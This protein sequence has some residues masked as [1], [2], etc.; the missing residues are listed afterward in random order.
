MLAKPHNLYIINGKKIKR[1]KSKDLVKIN[2]HNTHAILLMNAVGKECNN[3]VM[4]VIQGC[5]I[6]IVHAYNH[7]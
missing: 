7:E 2:A 6:D 5:D 3:L 4:T 1:G